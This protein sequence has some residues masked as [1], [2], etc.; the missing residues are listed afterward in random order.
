MNEFI[1]EFAEDYIL[2]NEQRRC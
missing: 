1:A 2:N